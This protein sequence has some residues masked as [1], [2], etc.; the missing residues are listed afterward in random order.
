[1]PNSYDLTQLDSH[2]FEHMVNALAL[3]V[4]GKGVTGLAQGADGGR[5]G[6]LFGEAPYPTDTER[7]S[8]TWHIQSK[9]HKPH[10]TKNSQKWLISEAKKEILEYKEKKKRTTPDIW[11][12]A[13]NIEPSGA[14]AT[15]AY[16]VIK[17]EV[18]KAFGSGIKFDIWGGRKI[19]DFLTA[20]A[21]VAAQFGHFLT[22]GH[23]LSAMYEQIGDTSAQVRPIINHLILDQFN[24]QIYTKL[25]QA[26][27]TGPKP[28]IHEL[29]V[30][31]PAIPKEHSNEVYI[32]QTLVSTA[33]NVHRP[34]AWARFG[35]GWRVWATH[36][37][38]ARAIIL[39][40]GP[41]QG[42]STAGQFFAQIQRAALLL[43]H[44]SITT[45]PLDRE[46][47]NELIKV[48]EKLNFQPSTPRIPIS[49]ELK[50]FA[51]WHGTRSSIESKGILTYLCEKIASKIDQPVEGGTL[52]RAFE[53]R[54]WFVNFDGL[55][56]VPNDVKDQ[57]ADEVIRFVNV[58]LPQLDSDTLVLCTTRPQGYSGQFKNLNA[59][60]LDLSP[61]PP[62]I[63]LKCAE[64]VVKFST[65]QSEAENR[66]EIL[67]SAMESPQVR[68]LMTTPLQSHIM[69]IVVKEGGR[70]PEKR[71]E[72]FDNFYQVM[73]RRES[74]KNFPDT[75]ISQIL[76]EN[77]VLL[78][79]IHSRLGISL[80]STAEKSLGAET[81]LSREQFE[82]LARQ[83]V[84]KYEDDKIDAIVKTLM[85]A[86]VQ[87]LVFVSTPESSTS[88]R[89][90]IRQLQEFFAAEFLYYGI[91][92]QQLKD[93]LDTIGSDSHWREVMHFAVS[94]L[95][96][97]NRPTELAVTIS[98][99]LGLDDSDSSPALRSYKRRIGAGS[100]MTLRLLHEGVLEQDRSVRMQFKETLV[101]IYG[102]M[103]SEITESLCSLRHPNT[104][105]W[106]LNGMID[107][108]FE[109]SEPEQINAAAVLA[110]KL[111][112][113]HSRRESVSKKIISS[114]ANYLNGLYL[115][116][117]GDHNYPFLSPEKHLGE[118][119]FIQLT[120][121]LLVAESLPTGLN[122]NLPLRYARSV[123]RTREDLENYELTED[124]KSAL[125]VALNINWRDNDQDHNTQ[126][127]E[128]CGIPLTQGRYTW[129]SE[130]LPE[131][132]ELLSL[133]SPA[134]LLQII[135]N[136]ISF[137]RERKLD[138]LKKLLG[139][140][141]THNLPDIIMQ[142]AIAP[143]MPF[144]IYSSSPQTALDFLSSISQLELDILIQ[145]E[146]KP[147][148]FITPPYGLSRFTS[149]RNLE[150]FFTI[151]TIHPNVA[152][153]SWL[154][155][156]DFHEP[157]SLSSFS[158]YS[159]LA[160]QIVTSSPASMISLFGGWGVVAKEQ[161]ELFSRLKPILRM[162]ASSIDTVMNPAKLVPFTLK[163]PEDIVFLPLAAK[164]L[165]SFIRLR[166][167]HRET[168][169]DI[170][171][172]AILTGYGLDTEKLK[173]IYEC[174]KNSIEQRAAALSCLLI[175][176]VQS[177]ENITDKFPPATL[178]ALFIE[179]FDAGIDSWFV[180]IISFALP[181]FDHTSQP[182]KELVGNILLSCR[183]RYNLRYE[184]QYLL[185]NF[186]E[187]SSAPVSN[188]GIL[189]SWL[190]D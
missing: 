81:T 168:G 177:D 26:G 104:L 120:L 39:K 3:T 106:L 30:D 150:Q 24:D 20:D 122:L 84:E 186:R 95:I 115:L 101:P 174:R 123:V 152:L 118:K 183:E 50:D 17:L 144:D 40:G 44:G 75:R 14:H 189:E 87:R 51:G 163:F 76:R 42:K 37:K 164:N 86:T 61:L 138:S 114:S 56:E 133:D 46:I 153:A 66:L 36:P 94:A 119:W 85:E 147:G 55:G 173:P 80:H 181:S 131:E 121:E 171:A 129:K 126:A 23:V 157:I 27:G 58:V 78:K 12:I 99:I 105:A 82:S 112:C 190:E 124:I 34:T 108:L 62:E 154:G 179:F 16:D 5:D 69:A 180:E 176:A 29:F 136:A 166:N 151:A 21:Q 64:G 49:I 139:L 67:K 97:T 110:Q 88:V 45:L 135:S 70:P 18:E 7:W 38:R 52:K 178:E 117:L 111:P 59:I 184:L 13:T 74:L 48:A 182:V 113:T 4:L 79:A 63:A 103:D 175:L 22:P 19:L 158:E 1:M 165:M 73:K 127:F 167:F 57:V 188:R 96:V 33:A 107:A 43:E 140:V 31:L 162:H 53:T 68:E 130:A 149:P 134:A 32:L 148:A 92:H 145:E 15:G 28:K 8:G 159:D 185:G 91:T 143:L 132:L 146:P 142:G 54:S 125:W 25:E 170:G 100:L 89:F 160:E 83:T 41:G 77:S 128:I 156:F 65:G 116:I 72:L 98:T 2:S 172:G 93:R 137:H 11:I 155:V 6:L 109:L 10:L 141:I 90:D 187:R 60:T 9:F 47:A 102:M 161:P 169:S 35:E 71:W